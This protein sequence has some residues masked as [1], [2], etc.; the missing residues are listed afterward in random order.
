M[1]LDLEP[2]FT[3]CR[4][5]LVECGLAT[6]HAVAAVATMFKALD[7]AG[8]VIMPVRISDE[9]LR[10][11]LPGLEPKVFAW[12]SGPMRAA[13]DAVLDEAAARQRARLAAG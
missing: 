10:V 4:E 8:A 1:E 11:A 13:I 3:A 6:D 5:R 2:V 9:L 7:Q 12:T